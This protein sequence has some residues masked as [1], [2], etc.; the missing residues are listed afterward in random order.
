MV[1]WSD[2][3][4]GVYLKH[5]TTLFAL[6]DHCILSREWRVIVDKV[7]IDKVHSNLWT[8]LRPRPILQLMQRSS[9]FIL[10]ITVFRL[11]TDPSNKNIQAEIIV[12]D[13]R[14]LI[15]VVRYNFKRV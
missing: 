11:C 3:I 14:L 5:T 7:Q 6:F 10:Y 13:E 12:K 1:L 9:G 8:R 15:A 4:T 2:H